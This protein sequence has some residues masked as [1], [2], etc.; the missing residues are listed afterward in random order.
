MPTIQNVARQ[1]WLPKAKSKP[2][3][4]ADGVLSSTQSSM[5]GPRESGFRGNL[6]RI[7][8]SGG[9][10]DLRRRGCDFEIVGKNILR[11]INAHP[12]LPPTLVAHRS[13][14]VHKE[15]RTKIS[16]I[17]VG[18]EAA[19]RSLLYREARRAD[20]ASYVRIL[21]PEE[22]EGSI[23]IHFAA[24]RVPRLALLIESEVLNQSRHYPPVDG[25]TMGPDKRTGEAKKASRRIRKFLMKDGMSNET[26]IPLMVA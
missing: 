13:C 19:G 20:N 4:E 17:P 3:S 1:R 6:C 7:P 21:L 11:P 26:H 18:V 23:D 15:P 12:P 22:K 10:P 8:W 9:G 2:Q 25:I 5:V 16:F 24:L 14:N